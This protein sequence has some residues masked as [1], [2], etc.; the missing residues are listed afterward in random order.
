MKILAF[1]SRSFHDAGLVELVIEGL[2]RRRPGTEGFTLVH[3]A[4]K[5][6]DSLAADA[7]RRLDW[8]QI[9]AYPADWKTHEGCNCA[10]GTPRCKFAGVRRN[11]DMLAA[12][13]TDAEPLDL[14]VGFINR[15]LT[16]SRGT[17]DMFKRLRT[18]EVAIWMVW[19]PFYRAADTFQE[20]PWDR[21]NHRGRVDVKRT[22]RG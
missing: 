4:A 15:P 20:P 9:R 12:E 21:G 16:S 18:A 5:G 14:A 13:H 6:A 7:A 17:H 19:A 10:P 22:D 3:G 2:Q 1:G 11:I 8:A